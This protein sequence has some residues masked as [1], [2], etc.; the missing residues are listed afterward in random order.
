M[1]LDS[2]KKLVAEDQYVVYMKKLYRVS[3]VD[4]DHVILED[5]KNNQVRANSGCFEILFSS[6][7]DDKSLNFRFYESLIEEL[8]KYPRVITKYD[9]AMKLRFRDS[10]NRFLTLG[11]EVKV[12]EGV[13]E[14]VD[15]YYLR[16]VPRVT[17]YNQNKG[18]II[19]GVKISNLVRVGYNQQPLD[20]IILQKVKL[21]R[22]NLRRYGGRPKGKSRKCSLI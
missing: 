12:S 7:F 15:M 9:L 6:F 4:E 19:W 21:L 13:Y 2:K 16:R 10:Q 5:K 17:L 11:S 8:K 20:R 14:I 1:V 3:T 18:T 22:E